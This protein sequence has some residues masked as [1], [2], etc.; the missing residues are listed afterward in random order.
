LTDAAALNLT[1]E[2][3][4]MSLK[5]LHN[6]REGE[7]ARN[8]RRVF[9][10]G[11]AAVGSITAVQIASAQ[12]APGGQTEGI[13]EITVTGS[14]I[15][16]TDTET[17]SPVQVI[18]AEEIK[19]SGFS[20]TAELLGSLTAN[21]QGT[22]SQSFTGAF[23]A[24]A[25]GIALR[26]LNV[27]YTLILIDGHRSAPYPI[28]DDGQR[29][30]VDTAS[31]PFDSIERIEILKDGA[32]SIYGSDAIAGVVNVILKKSFTGAQITADAGTTNHADGTMGH[33]AATFGHGDLETD[34]YNGF[35]A[36][37]ARHQNQVR[38]IDRGGIFTQTDFSGEGGLNITPGVP[39]AT[40]GNVAGS[41]TGYILNATGSAPAAFLPGC[42]ATSYAAGLC[43]FPNQTNILLPETTNYNAL[44]K[45][46]KKLASEWTLGLEG[47]YFQSKSQ[48]VGGNFSAQGAG[49]FSTVG[50]GPGIPPFVT[51]ATPPTI[52]TSAN[53]AFPQSLIAQGIT[54]GRLIDTLFNLGGP[55]VDHTDAKTY[56]AIANLDGKVGSWDLNIAAGFTDVRLTQ[57]WTGVINPGAFEAALNS[58]TDPFLINQPNDA[59]VINAVSPIEQ[60]VATSQLEFAHA[61]LSNRI[62]DLPGGGLG[63]AFGGDFFIRRQDLIAPADTEAG[64]VRGP[65]NTFTVGDQH[66]YAGFLELQA[67]VLKSLELDAAVRY[68]HYNLSGGKAS[69]KL[70]IIWK[71]VSEF[72]LRGTASKGFRAPSPAENGQAGQTFIAGTQS[73]PILC[74]DPSSNTA[75]GN[76]LGACNVPLPGQQT[77]NPALKPETSKAFTLGFVIEPTRDFSVDV[78]LYS[79]EIDNQIVSAPGSG[80]VRSTSLSPLPQ[81]QANGTTVLVAPPVGPIIFSPSTF[82][83]ADKTYTNGWDFD[84]DY[85]H[86]FENGVHV[87]STVSWTYVHEL[88]FTLGGQHFQLAGT[89]APSFFTGDTGTPKSRASWSNT[90]G[91]GGA[92]VTATVNYIGSFNQTDTTSNFFQA[93]PLDTCLESL[94]SQ[95]GAAGADFANLLNQGII[96]AATSCNVNHFTTVDLFAKYEFSSHLSVHGSILNLFDNKAP[97]DWGTYAAAGTPFNPSFHEQGAL[98]MT[99]SVGATYNF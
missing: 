18:T 52:L 13:T 69:P 21:S 93:T 94:D 57:T 66:V 91:Y 28:G 75:P 64:L 7:L 45:F 14:H 51:T 54:S 15:R 40:N 59:A 68:D 38:M 92:S 88:E 16:R 1:K 43:A 83:N 78:D 81:F 76:F 36:V 9:F 19:Q 79:I 5:F 82:I 73:D 4:E 67:P 63:M 90:I 39:T 50:S 41:A 29:S 23:A 26:G 32:S 24:G 65:A 85:H 20:T 89:H 34:G 47:T 49:N 6:P 30:F 44:G 99:F 71:P 10:V 55:L 53:P 3:K 95:G 22:L 2:Q 27:G 25:S 77:T 87:K 48:A 72:M 70:G 84:V 61:G 60:S 12:T 58:P 33:I 86:T 98:G 62:L 31:I 80:P 74:R 56:R 42:N 35:I 11:V 97:L 17:S 46:T 8:M 96:P 37:E